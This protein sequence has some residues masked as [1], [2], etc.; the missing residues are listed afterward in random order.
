MKKEYSEAEMD[1][2]PFECDDVIL[3]SG[4]NNEEDENL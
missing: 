1:I 4:G 3:T 2:I